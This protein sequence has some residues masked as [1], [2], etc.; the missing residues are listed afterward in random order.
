[1]TPDELLA[2]ARDC[3]NDGLEGHALRRYHKLDELLS[4]GDPL[5]HDWASA[6]PAAGDAMADASRAAVAL[7]HAWYD[8]W[9]AVN[10][11]GQQARQ[12]EGA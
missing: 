9:E 4:K 7:V 11:L 6:A 8:F 12:E 1:M 10:R 2:A 5:P 3:Y